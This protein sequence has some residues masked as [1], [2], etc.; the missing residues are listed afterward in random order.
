LL[1]VTPLTKLSIAPALALL[2][3]WLPRN[4]IDEARIFVP[5]A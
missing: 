2:K 4:R 3:V 1:T 5:L